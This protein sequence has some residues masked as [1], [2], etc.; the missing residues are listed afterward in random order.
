[1]FGRGCSHF[2]DHQGLENLPLSST[3]LLLMGGLGVS[4][5]N[6]NRSAFFAWTYLSIVFVS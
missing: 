1:M 4:L 6:G 5:A 3:T 2:R